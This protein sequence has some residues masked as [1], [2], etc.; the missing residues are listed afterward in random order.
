MRKWVQAIIGCAFLGISLVNAQSDADKIRLNQIGFYPDGEKVAI[1]VDTMGGKYFYLLTNDASKDTVYKG[2]LSKKAQWEYSEEFVRK[3]DFSDFKDKGNYIL[4]MPK[5]GYSH[6]FTIANGVMSQV[7]T[8]S[9]KAYYYQRTAI[10]LQSKYAGKFAR[11][12]GHPDDKVIIHNSAAFGNRKTGD[13]IKSSKGWYDAGDYNK[14]IVNSGITMYTLLS[15]Y[16]DFP[17]YFDTLN[18]NIPESN[19]KLP[20]VLDEILWNLRWMLTMQDPQDGGVY[21]KLTN[22]GW[23]GP[24]QPEA[25][26]KPRYVVKKSTNATLDFAAVMAQASRIFGKF[27]KQLP[28]LSDSCLK[29]SLSAYEW[30]KKNNNVPYIQ[31]EL[32]DPTVVTGAYDDFK[33]SDEILWASIELFVTT[34]KIVYYEESGLDVLINSNIIVANWQDVGELGLYTLAKNSYKFRDDPKYED[35]NFDAVNKKIIK[36]AKMLRTHKGESPYGVPMGN[37]Y[38]DFAWGSNAIAANQGFLLLQAF[39]LTGDRSYVEAAN[40][41]LDYLLGRNATTYSFLTGYG[42]KSTR[43]PHHRPSESDGIEDPIPG[44]LAGGP[45]PGQQDKGSCGSKAYPSSL[46]AQSYIDKRCSYASN[47][48]AINWNAPFA[49]LSNG[50]QAIRAGNYTSYNK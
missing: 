48:I 20:D 50:L 28:G 49:Y 39:L 7:A 14:Y 34:G 31:S 8:A 36:I 13:L 44:F 19:N 1:V 40:A 6:P 46:P 24:I 29:A 33:F 32:N 2:R 41:S 23:D 10:D 27:R 5:V 25:A 30:G 17:F 42:E 4:Y 35:I 43:D 47:E 37:E 11:K 21:H 15:L 12:A 3:A 18:L 9:L 16:E 26:T 45:N 22:A 38:G